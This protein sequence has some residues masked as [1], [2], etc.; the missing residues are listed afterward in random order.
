MNYYK[1]YLKYKNKYIELLKKNGGASRK[2]VD[3]RPIIQTIWTNFEDYSKCQYVDETRKTHLINIL[4]AFAFQNKANI[5]QVRGDGNCLLYSVCIYLYLYIHNMNLQ[6][7]EDNFID[8]LNKCYIE[9]HIKSDN[10]LLLL[11]DFTSYVESVKGLVS[12]NFKLLSDLTLKKQAEQIGLDIGIPEQLADAK[13]IFEFN[14]EFSDEIPIYSFT[15]LGQILS[16][17]LDCVI[18]TLKFQ[19]EPQ[20]YGKYPTKIYYDYTNEEIM[21]MVEND[22]WKVVFIYNPSE[23]HYYSFLSEILPDSKTMPIKFLSKHYFR[24]ILDRIQW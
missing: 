6:N 4:K 13:G 8:Y 22:T 9:D 5:I 10:N 17:I 24:R 12:E 3:E 20:F 2:G 1:K 16:T 15:Q 18:I 23:I 19:Y 14:D 11:S 21:E 7:L